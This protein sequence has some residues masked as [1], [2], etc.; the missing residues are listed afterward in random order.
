MLALR[1]LS[2]TAVLWSALLLSTLA[3]CALSPQLVTIKPDLRVPVASYGAQRDVNVRAEDH[4]PGNVIG[5]RGGIYGETSTIEIGNNANTE[6]AYS[7]AAGLT[8][9][10]FRSTVD[11]HRGQALEFAVVLDKLNYRPDGSVAGK[12]VVEAEVSIVVESGD[13]TYRGKYAA[14]KELVYATA[15][16]EEKNNAAINEV[17]SLALEKIFADQGLV[18]FLR[19]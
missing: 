17:L 10:G 2:V 6:I 9:W 4:R 8:R 12:L 5:T 13:H 3:G 7:M 14:S 16:S 19:Q 18:A 11:G 1:V 15:P